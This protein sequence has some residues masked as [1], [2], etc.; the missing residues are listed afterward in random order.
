MDC[1][2]RSLLL[3]VVYSSNRLVYFESWKVLD[4]KNSG[5]TQAKDKLIA[6]H[7]L[8]RVYL[9]LASGSRLWIIYPFSLINISDLLDTESKSI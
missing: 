5:H 3:Y 6:D 9:V 8:F 7:T 1:F 4:G 2:T